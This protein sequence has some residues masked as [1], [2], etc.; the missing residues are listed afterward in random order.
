MTKGWTHDYQDRLFCPF[1]SESALK[2]K[3]LHMWCIL[4]SHSLKHVYNYFDCLLDQGT[5]VQR[6]I[7]RNP[8]LNFNPTFFFLCSKVFKGKFSLFLLEHPMIKLQAKRFELNFLLKFSD[9]KSNFTLTLG[10][11]TRG[12]NFHSN[13]DWEFL[14]IPN[15]NNSG[16]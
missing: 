5:L 3:N 14:G 8:G 2:M 11:G 12:V 7:S 1:E 10:Q 13:S 4:I 6:P 15:C 9:L 16:S